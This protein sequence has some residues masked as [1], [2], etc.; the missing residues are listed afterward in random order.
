MKIAIVGGGIAGLATAY[1]LQT[2]GKGAIEYTLIDSAPEFGGKIKSEREN[3][4]VVEGG[5]DSFI[6]QK[7]TILELCRE[8]QIDQDLL[9]TN[10]IARKIF[11]WSRGK[12]QPMPDGVMLIIP[13]KI[14]PF[15]KSTLI[16]WPGKIR[17]GLDIV[18]PKRKSDEDESL[19]HFIRRRLGK[20]ALE[21]LAEPMVAGIYVADAETLSLK[22]S[23]PRFMD[24]EKKYGSLL[25]AILAQKRAAKKAPVKGKG[26]SSVAFVS[27]KNGL[28]ELVESLLERLNPAA[29]RAGVS[30]N[31]IQPTGDQYDLSLSDGSHLQAD[32]VIFATPAF[33]TAQLVENI[34]PVVASKLRRIRY[35]STATVSLG[36]KRSDLDNG[37]GGFGFVVP[38]REKRKIL[39]CTWSSTKFN[40]RAPDGHVLLRAFIGGAH[41]EDLAEQ[42]DQALVDMVRQ[43]IKEMMGITAEPVLAKVFHWYKANPQYEVGHLERVAEIEK[44]V[45]KYPGLY[46]VGA[47]YKGVGIPDC[48]TNAKQLVEGILQN[49]SAKAVPVAG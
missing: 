37:L 49:S 3:G 39:A 27:F 11:I 20:E 40:F 29:L 9:N 14:M 22:S 43:E 30:V 38:R 13:T 41:N 4:F 7:P 33:V 12:L 15:L 2:R 5:P 19:A 6:T 1:Y 23:Q 16:S 45:A 47:A 24:M 48:V 26:G 25:R 21:I 28:Q 34:A 32:A 35:A 8:L 36:F 42:D 46:L 17:M 10:D 31:A 18:I 44:L